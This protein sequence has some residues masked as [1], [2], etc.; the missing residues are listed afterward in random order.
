[1]AKKSTK[2]ST[3]RRKKAAKAKDLPAGRKAKTVKGGALSPSSSSP[4]F[5]NSV[6]GLRFTI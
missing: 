4:G 5:R 2:G 1:M 3:S 6:G